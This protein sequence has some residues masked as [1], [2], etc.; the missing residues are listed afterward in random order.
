MAITFHKN[1]YF[2]FA[3]FALAV[4]A[5]WTALS[6]H[7][8]F[9]RQ[10]EASDETVLRILSGADETEILDSLKSTFGDEYGEAVFDTWRIYKG[11]EEKAPGYY[12]FKKGDRVKDIARRLRSGDQTPVKVKFNTVRKFEQLIPSITDSLAITPRE[13]LEAA[14][15]ILPKKGY[16]EENFIAAFLPD[17]Y[18]FYWTST[19]DEVVDRLL[20]Y[21]D[22]F[23]NAERREKAK[24][25]NLTPQQVATLASIVDAETQA[26]EEKGVV[27]RLYL[28]RLKKGMRLQAD[29]TVIYA[30]GDFNIKRVT[31]DM[32]LTPSPYNTYQV[33][34]LPPGPIRMPEKATIDN[35][36]NAPEHDFLYMCARETLDGRHNFAK[37]LNEHNAN[38]HRYQQE[39]NRRGIK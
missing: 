22:K 29:P 26:P 30:I 39:L 7:E 11:T 17:T 35:V 8:K 5:A 6:Y 36:L 25:L 23:W 34:G 24:A 19:P 37:T 12:R 13:F 38:A 1:K 18:E 32:L 31:N 15:R 28:N 33:D 16:N 2:W 14:R 9:N 4:A 10:W 27:A 3:I 21:H 20:Y